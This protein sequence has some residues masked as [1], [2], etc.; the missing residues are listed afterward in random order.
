MTRVRRPRLFPRSGLVL[1][2]KILGQRFAQGLRL[3]LVLDVAGDRVV[4]LGEDDVRD[5]GAQRAPVLAVGLMAR[6]SGE[7]YGG[8]PVM[9]VGPGVAEDVEVQ[10][11]W[12]VTAP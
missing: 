8:S 6:R 5:G 7:A 4:A 3:G 2:E 10:L 1:A 12:L 11:P 9:S